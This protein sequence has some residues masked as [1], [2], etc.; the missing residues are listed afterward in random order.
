MVDYESALAIANLTQEEI[1]A[2]AHHENMT[3]F[4]AMEMGNYLCETPQGAGLFGSDEGRR[5]T[6]A[7]QAKGSSAGVRG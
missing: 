6:A 7:F 3:A 2:I 5:V 4:V 1:D